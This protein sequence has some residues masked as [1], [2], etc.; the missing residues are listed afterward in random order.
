MAAVPQVI[1]DLKDYQSEAK[2]LLC[3][4]VKDGS[5]PDRKLKASLALLETDPEQR[6]YLRERLRDCSLD[7]FPVIVDF[8]KRYR[9]EFRDELRQQLQGSTKSARATDMAKWERER[10]LAGMALAN[11]DPDSDFWGKDENK[12]ILRFLATQMVKANPEDQ[13]ALH[14]HLKPIA[15]AW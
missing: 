3:Q 11:Y 15:G 12:D 4:Q 6:H 7:E 2:S 14:S 9:D 8:L 13:Y 1:S 10:L 5:D